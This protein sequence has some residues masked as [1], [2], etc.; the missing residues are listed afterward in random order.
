MNEDGIKELQE[1]EEVNVNSTEDAASENG[2]AK[3]TEAAENAETMED[4]ARELEASYK[5]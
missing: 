5:E 3:A 2:D 4:Y 1:T